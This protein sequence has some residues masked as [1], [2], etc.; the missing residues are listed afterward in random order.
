MTRVRFKQ[1][2]VTRALRGAQAAGMRIGKVEIDPTGKIVI[3][4]DTAAPAR[5]SANPW[6]AELN[7]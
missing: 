4:S 5:G 7:R 6:D 2:D 3:L 1:A